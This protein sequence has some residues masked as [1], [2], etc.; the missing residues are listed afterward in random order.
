MELTRRAL[1]AT[2]GGAIVGAHAWGKRSNL[3]IGVTDWNLRQTGKVEA[4]ELA[5]SL[6]FEGVEV[7]LGRRVVDNKL[8]LD[9]AELQDQYLAA[10]KK[11]GIAL[12]G[13][14]LN[15]LHVNYLTN[16]KLGQ[17]WVADGIPITKKLKARVMLLPFFGKGALQT[18]EE[19]DYVAGALKDLAREAEKAGIILGL[20][21]T[22]SAENNVRIMD[23]VAS[24]ALLVYYDVGNSTNGGFDVVKEIQWLGA[25]R[26][27][28]FHL[29]D[30]PHYLGQG[31][32]QFP[33]VMDTI[34]N[35]GFSGFA[36]LETDSPSKSVQDDMR[37]NLTFVRG[38]MGEQ[39]RS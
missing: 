8:P 20:E 32:I 36:N 22:I 23:K 30:N 9:N 27:C 5:K 21:N 29:K 10:A 31:K 35:L 4:V 2:A 12:A 17:K 6:G 14:C 11:H 19:M 39:K 34:M 7:S 25:K 33:A 18:A 28:Q 37:K 24:K 16:D 13:T 3:K 38:L 15:V 1:L 26:I